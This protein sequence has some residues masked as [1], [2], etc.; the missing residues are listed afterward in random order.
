MDKKFI[1]IVDDEENICLLYKEELLAEGYE[2]ETVENAELALE[3]L[4]QH[5]V[6]LIVLDIMMPGMDGLE[7]LGCI[8]NIDSQLPIILCSAY[9]TYKQD[10]L[11]WGANAYVKKSANMMELKDTIHQYLT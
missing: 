6:D 10:F 1:M 5:Q 9:G 4:K 2:V 3:L 7:L 11:T 8:R